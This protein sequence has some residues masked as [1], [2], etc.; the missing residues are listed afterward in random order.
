MFCLSWLCVYV[1]FVCQGTRGLAAP[2]G[3]GA[4]CYGS[5]PWGCARGAPGATL[6]P[7]N[8]HL[9]GDGPRLGWD[10]G[11]QVV[12]AWRGPWLGRAWLWGDGDRPC[13]NM[14]GCPGGAE[15]E[16]WVVGRVGMSRD[17][18]REQRG[19]TSRKGLW[20]RRL[21]ATPNK[22]QRPE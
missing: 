11:P 10:L 3:P 9:P 14:T 4:V 15:R 17:C 7:G 20:N 22:S 19:R 13:C 2:C 6:A 5:S 18:F 1:S 8:E 21:E 12:L 16:S